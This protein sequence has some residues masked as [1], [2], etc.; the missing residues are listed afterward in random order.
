MHRSPDIRPPRVAV[1]ADKDLGLTVADFLDEGRET[2]A[3][4]LLAFRRDRV[5]QVEDR[6][7]RFE[8]LMALDL[9][10]IVRGKHHPGTP[11]IIIFCHS[12]CLSRFLGRPRP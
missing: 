9:S 1:D 7:V 10:G 11:R 4:G 5:L 12:H 3:R 6:H 8:F 2:R